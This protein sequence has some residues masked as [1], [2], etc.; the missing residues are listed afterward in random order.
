LSSKTW[1][2]CGY[3]SL[4]KREPPNLLIKINDTIYIANL[5]EAIDVINK[6]KPFTKIFRRKT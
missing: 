2:V 5:N 4:T 3:L 1:Q 6:K